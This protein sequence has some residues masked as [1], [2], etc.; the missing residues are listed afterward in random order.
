MNRR[1][2]LGRG[3]G[4]SMAM[5]GGGLMVPRVSGASVPTRAGHALRMPPAWTGETLIVARGSAPVWPGSLTDVLAVNGSIPGPTIRVRRGEE[6]A[7]R[8]LNHLDQPLVLH[9]HGVLAPERMD[10]HPRDQVQSGQGYDVRFTVPQRGAACWYHSHTDGLTAKQAY[11]GVAGLFLIEDPAE[12]ALGLPTGGHDVP[13]VLTDKR[14]SAQK[15][16]VYAPSMMDSM[17]GYLGD[18]MLVNGTPE[19]WLSVDRGL[20]RFRLLNGCNARICKVEFSDGHP[21]KVIATDGGL[22]AAPVEARSVMLAPGQRI[23]LLVDFSGHPLDTSVILRSSAF[24]GG[25][26]MS[27]GGPAQGSAIDLMRIFIDRALTGNAEVPK[28]LGPFT[29]LSQSDAKRTRVFTLAMSGMVHTINGRLFD[30][31]R[32]DF[33]VPFGEVEIW[34]YR[35]TGTEPHPMHAHAAHCQVLSRSTTAQLPPED[36]GWKDTIL[37]NP[38]ETVRVAMRFDSHPG[39][40]VHH[41]HNLEHEDS[42]MMQNFEVLGPPALAIERDGGRVS[43]FWP[44]SA[45]G[46]R[47][48]ASTE[49][50]GSSWGPV[51]DVPVAVGQRWTVRIAEPTGPRFYRLVKG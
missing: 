22:L 37:V 38:G 11:A 31:H 19:A 42:G 1:D 8:I 23:E 36:T 16:W 30:V 3:L 20:Y 33:T 39:V 13:L 6:F 18:T 26:G 7:A 28:S 51:A 40:F 17:S 46:W 41:C 43:L 34:E 9:W 49:A 5:A 50:A 14:V 25:G 10:G 45:E 12:S 15:Q 2:F 4:L 44:E 47:L 21:F 24:A 27:M 35:N 32:V 29:T 48:E